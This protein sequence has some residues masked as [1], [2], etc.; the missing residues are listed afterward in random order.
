[1]RAPASGVILAPKQS[2]PG[3]QRQ[4]QVAKPANRF[5]GSEQQQAAWKQTVVKQGYQSLLQLRIE[6]DQQDCGRKADR[7]L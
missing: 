1:M 5:R 2:Q 7:A 3:M 6:V 4:K